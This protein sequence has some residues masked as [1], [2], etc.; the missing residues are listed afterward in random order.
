MIHIIIPVYRG[1]AETR[2]CIESVL[3]TD[4]SQPHR[5]TIIDDCSPDAELTDYLTTLSRND[6]VQVLHNKQNLGFVATVNRGMELDP[7]ADV[8]LLNSDTEV[9]GDWLDRL[10]RCAYSATDIGTVTPFSNNATICSY[11]K[12]CHDNALP[13]GWDIAELDA[14]FRQV[15]ASKSVEIPTAVGF[16]MYIRRA[17]LNAVGLFDVERF[18]KGYGEEN[19][20]CM[21]ARKRGWRHLLCAD[22]FVFHAGGVSFAETQ[23]ARKQV[24][25]QVLNRLHPSYPYMVQQHIRKDPARPYRLMVDFMRLKARSRPVVLFV[26]HRRGGGTERHIQELATHLSDQAEVLALRPYLWK[27]IALEWTRYGERFR[28]YFHMDR[29]YPVLLNVLKLAG[30]TQI[31]FHHLFGH[32]PQIK[33]LPI[34]INTPFDFTVH[35]YFPICPRISLTS[36]DQRYCGEHGEQQCNS[37]LQAKPH[38]GTKNIRS[39]R[40][41]Y[42]ALLGKAQRVFAPSE[43]TA[44]RIRCYFNDAK[45]VY[46]PHLD[47]TPTTCIPT[48]KALPLAPQ[49][50]LRIVVIGAMS[51][52][53]GA[54]ILARCAILAAEHQLPLQFHLIGYAYKD[55]DELSPAL[56][57]HGEYK[58]ADLEKL[59]CASSP[60][61]I[62]F[63]AQWPETYSYTLSAA[64]LSGL[65][66]A[67][68]DIGA[69]PERIGS[70]AWSWMCPWN[71]SAD[72][73]SDFFIRVRENN[74]LS[75]THPQPPLDTPASAGYQYQDYLHTSQVP[76][77]RECDIPAIRELLTKHGTPQFNLAERIILDSRRVFN[78]LLRIIRPASRTAK[79]FGKLFSPYNRKMLNAWLNGRWPS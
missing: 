53:K 6:R 19:D 63:P 50:K 62:W 76:P 18:G 78:L 44:R 70:R 36:T 2:R 69:F 47:I 13:E 64:L 60:H 40:A 9:T 72:E 16:C 55:M 57:V 7:H 29:D 42:A 12:F 1:L 34:D 22:T 26:T 20:F 28:L 24:A 75:A 71:W 65:P 52:M 14:L 10:H 58:D 3:R 33:N 23:N 74:F 43:D 67:A 56:S 79:T 61:L 15:N 49:E 68:P 54:D 59:I 32:S 66:I 8:I 31:H 51:Q 35:D 21:R 45:I 37:C 4:N 41:Q 25:Q 38:T 46:A 48:P 5:I 11:P 17:S 73:W 27:V 39:W 77:F 30:V